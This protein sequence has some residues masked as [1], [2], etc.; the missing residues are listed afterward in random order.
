MGA[1][2][3]A[4]AIAIVAI[5]LAGARILSP[6]MAALG[7]RLRGRPQIASDATLAADLEQVRA[8]LAEVEERLDF[9]ERLLARGG[10]ADQIPS[11]ANR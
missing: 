4:E 1:L 8:R 3:A 6:I 9:A 10:G 7:H 5:A 11:G 2:N